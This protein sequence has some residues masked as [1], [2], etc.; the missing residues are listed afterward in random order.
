MLL[1]ILFMNLGTKGKMGVTV[2]TVV[3]G[4]KTHEMITP[5][6]FKFIAVDVDGKVIDEDIDFGSRYQSKL[7]KHMY[8]RFKLFAKKHGIEVVQRGHVKQF[9]GTNGITVKI[10]P[11]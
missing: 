4:T 7:R 1:Q 3:T 5:K 2:V 9:T 11:L 6:L 8:S 10:V